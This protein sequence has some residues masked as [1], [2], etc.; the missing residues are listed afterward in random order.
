MREDKVEFVKKY[1]R[2]RD[3]QGVDICNRFFVERYVETFSAPSIAMI[4][5]ADKCP[6][7]GRL[8]GDMFRAGI[9]KRHRAGIVGFAGEG[10]PKW[11]YYY[12]L[13]AEFS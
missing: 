3:P 11:V 13:S 6:Q 12:T 2:D 9:L 4:Y 10:F 1:L 8:L 7:L 5:G